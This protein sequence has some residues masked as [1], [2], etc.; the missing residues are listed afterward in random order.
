MSAL[1]TEMLDSTS[2]SAVQL[3]TSNATN[4]SARYNGYNA[5]ADMVS[6][7]KTALS[8]MKIELDDEVAGK[9]VEQTVTRAVY[10]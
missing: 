1:K 2:L 6:A 7:F 3:S 5:Q 4:N 8:E 10:T 9:F